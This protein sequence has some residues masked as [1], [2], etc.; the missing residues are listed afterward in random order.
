[1]LRFVGPCFKDENLYIAG[2][3]PATNLQPRS[4]MTVLASPFAMISNPQPQP[5]RSR[6]AREGLALIAATGLSAL[7]LLALTMPIDVAA[8]RGVIQLPSWLSVGGADDARAILSAILGSVSTVLALIFSVV[9]LVLSIAMSQLGPRL[10]RRFVADRL[11]RVTVGAFV[12]TFVQSLAALLIVRQHHGV[13]FVPQITCLCSV[14]LV[15]VSFALLIVYTHRVAVTIQAGN[16]VADVVIDLERAI[17]E[18]SP[19]RVIDIG[20]DASPAPGSSGPVAS[21][22]AAQL[23]ARCDV[24]GGVL[25]SRRAGYVQHVEHEVLVVAAA[26]AGVLVKMQVRAGQFVMPGT[27]LARVL[28]ATRLSSIERELFAAVRLGR[29]RTLRQD[30]EFG[31]AQVVEVA[32]RALS[33]A[34]NDTFTGLTCIDWLGEELRAL[35]LLPPSDWAW[36][37]RSGEVRLIEVPLKFP[38]MVK[39]AFDQIRQASTGNP[40]VVIR[41]CRALQRLGNVVVDSGYRQAMREQLLALRETSALDRLASSDHA[42]VEDAARLALAALSETS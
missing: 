8:A 19:N 12:A 24:E 4:A 2:R 32:L 41:M 10:L 37:T 26:R 18:A 6:E 39:T 38:R 42:D 25:V 5:V 20:E 15:L 16:V 28:P 40:A 11:W 13:V 22:D 34:V 9:L 29:H 30:L 27:Q 3:A 23:A 36:R 33:P 31:I 7:P 21:G 17:R 1:M 14:A 35:A